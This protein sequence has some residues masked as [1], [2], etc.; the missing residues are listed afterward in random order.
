MTL[1]PGSVWLDARATQ[2][3]T[4]AERGLARFVAEHTRALIR[5]APEVIG[6]IGLD[7]MAPLPRSLEP[8]SGSGLIR[9]HQRTR[10]PEGEPPAIY[11]VG[12]PFEMSMDF[13]AVWPAWE[14]GRAHV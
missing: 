9:W 13:D 7:R 11:H 2:S 8:L 4:H 3:A 10:P 1:T 12:S 14:I 6:A 5:I